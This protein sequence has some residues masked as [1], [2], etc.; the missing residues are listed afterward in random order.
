M[1]LR[2]PTRTAFSYLK[3]VIH[4]NNRRIV[5]GCH[6]QIDC[7]GLAQAH[8]AVVVQ[9]IDR[10]VDLIR[11]HVV[12]NRAIGQTIGTRIQRGVDSGNRALNDDGRI[13]RSV[14]LGK[15]NACGR[16]Q[17]QEPVLRAHGQ[18][19]IIGIRIHVPY[20]DRVT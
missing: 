16:I 17:G 5:H 15:E 9:I 4:S 13:R 14:S 20:L 6:I 19:H 10:H 7:P 2:D 1:I 3:S 12:G 11:A 8:V 18:S